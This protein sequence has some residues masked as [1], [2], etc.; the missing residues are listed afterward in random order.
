MTRG[1]DGLLSL[2]DAGLLPPVAHFPECVSSWADLMFCFKELLQ[3]SDFRTVVLDTLNGAERLAQEHTC[4]TH[5]SGDWTSFDAYGRG[6]K[7]TLPYIIELTQA[8]DRLRE[9]GKGIILLA[10]SQVK[11]FR[12]PQG[13]DYDRWEPVLAKESW[14]HLDRWADMVLFGQFEVIAEE[15]K[16][17]KA[18]ARGGQTR[19]IQTERTAAYDAGNRLGLPEEIECGTS[20]REAWGNFIQAIKHGKE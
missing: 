15:K 2:M 14:A 20:A 12:N 10:H 1:E 5:C 4:Q 3:A 7:L 18:K 8:L 9:R 17:Q 11:T 13:P 6:V 19:L 16:G